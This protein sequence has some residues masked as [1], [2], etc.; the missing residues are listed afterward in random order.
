LLL[1]VVVIPTGVGAEAT[2]E[3]RDLVLLFGQQAAQLTRDRA[4]ERRFS[5]A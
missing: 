1:S 2:A 3:W 4:E 5:A